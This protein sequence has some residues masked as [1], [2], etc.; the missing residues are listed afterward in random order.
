MVL[1][2]AF[3]WVLAGCSAAGD[4][5]DD[6]GIGADTSSIVIEEAGLSEIVKDSDLTMINLWATYCNPCIN[7]MPDLGEVASEYEKQDVQVVGVVLD[8]FDEEGQA[9]DEQVSKAKELIALTK[10]NYRHLLPTEDL[11]GA[12]AVNISVV[13]TTLFFGRDGEMVGE[14]VLGSKSKEAWI[15]EIET[16]LGELRSE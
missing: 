5:K 6:G 10:A 12:F 11:L 9:V 4:R 8:V 2:I 13:P 16:R 1:S 14:P 3:F 15:D 7:E